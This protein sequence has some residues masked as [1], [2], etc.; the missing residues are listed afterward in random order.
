VPQPLNLNVRSHIENMDESKIQELLSDKN[1]LKQLLIES[2]SETIELIEYRTFDEGLCSANYFI[3]E[4]SECQDA[5]KAFV[6]LTNHELHFY[7][8]WNIKE[9]TATD[10][11]TIADIW[12]KPNLKALMAK[13]IN[14][15]EASADIENIIFS[16]KERIRQKSEGRSIL[17]PDRWGIFQNGLPC[18]TEPTKILSPITSSVIALIANWNEIE[19][20]YETPSTYVLFSWSTGA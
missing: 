19:Y 12:L 20:F 2:L 13:K 8:E 16:I 1:L 6:A 14:A 17:N 5:Q 3:C 7:E 11:D 15:N 10:L 4:K 9:T 18:S